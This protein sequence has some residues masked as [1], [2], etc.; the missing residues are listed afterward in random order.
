[1]PDQQENVVQELPDS[2]GEQMAEQGNV[3]LG[4]QEQSKAQGETIKKLEE[5]KA[6]LE[7]RLTV[8]IIERDS[9]SEKLDNAYARIEELKSNAPDEVD[10][11]TEGPLPI[12][13]LNY[14]DLAP[15]YQIAAD[16]NRMIYRMLLR[17]AP[18]RAACKRQPSDG[19]L[20]ARLILNGFNGPEMVNFLTETYKIT[21]SDMEIAK[22]RALGE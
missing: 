13:T 16:L 18:W 10:M 8:V 9:L 4:L 19:S 17:M 22:T 1:M 7:A 6:E 15:R 20:A 5:E 11:E 14:D 3:I 12:R 21:D 2:L